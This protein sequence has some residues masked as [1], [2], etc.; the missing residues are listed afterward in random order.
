[1]GLDLDRSN[2]INE[3]LTSNNQRFPVHFTTCFWLDFHISEYWKSGQLIGEIQSVRKHQPG[4]ISGRKKRL[5]KN[6]NSSTKLTK[7]SCPLN[8]NHMS[9]PLTFYIK[10]TR[11]TPAHVKRSPVHK[12]SLKWPLLHN[13]IIKVVF[14]THIHPANTPTHTFSWPACT[15]EKGWRRAVWFTGLP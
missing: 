11:R 13:P 3:F 8:I 7:Q 9:Y 1:M 15:E 6:P 12:T 10:C 5:V 14:P 2:K 4:S